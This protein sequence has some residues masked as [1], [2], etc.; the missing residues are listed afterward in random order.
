MEEC[1]CYVSTNE[2][3]KQH[4]KGYSIEFINKAKS[5]GCARKQLKYTS[6]V[7]FMDSLGL[8]S[9]VIKSKHPEHLIRQVKKWSITF[10][11]E[12]MCLTHV[13]DHGKKVQLTLGKKYENIIDST[14]NNTYRPIYK[15]QMQ[16]QKRQWV[17]VKRIKNEYWPWQNPT[18]W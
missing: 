5:S 12:T 3:T 1:D 4:R 7:K 8:E 9:V 10:H 15:I 17:E 6:I 2:I 16:E 14:F 18:S 11:T 13:V